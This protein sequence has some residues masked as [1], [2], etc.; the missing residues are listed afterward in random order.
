VSKIRL[1]D[2]NAHD[3]DHHSKKQDRICTRNGS[4]RFM[5]ASTS[6]AARIFARL[7]YVTISQPE[8]I[9]PNGEPYQNTL[10][11]FD[12]LLDGGRGVRYLGMLPELSFVDRRNPDAAIDLT[13]PEKSSSRKCQ[14]VEWICSRR[15]R[16]CPGVPRL[17]T[18]KQIGKFCPAKMQKF[19]IN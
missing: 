11:D 1:V 7:P 15:R 9:Q 13:P 12:I 19:K 18:T 4:P 16:K 6:S 3:V 10:A 5:S 2:R 8:P 14:R 17:L